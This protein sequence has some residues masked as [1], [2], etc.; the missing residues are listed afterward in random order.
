MAYSVNDT[1]YGFRITNIRDSESL[2]GALYE[3]E[4]IKTGAQLCWAEDWLEN[5]LFC[6]GFQTIPENSTGVFHILEHSV[7]C[8]SDQYPVREPFVELLKGSMNTFLNAMTYPDKT[9]YPVSS[10]NP[11]DFYNLTSVY[12]DAVF[13]PAILHNKNIFYQEGHH[14]ELSDEGPSNVGVVYNEMKGVMSSIDDCIEL[15]VESILFPDTCYSHNSGGDPKEILNL[16]YEEFIDTYKTYYHPSN[17]KIFL[18]GDINLDEILPLIDSY[19]SRYEKKEIPFCVKKQVPTVKQKTI[20]YDS[21]EDKEDSDYLVF[22]KIVSDYTTPEKLMALNILIGVLC[23]T[24]DSPLQK[25]LL[26]KGLAKD[27]DLLVTDGIIQPYSILLL[28]NTNTEKEEEIRATIKEVVETLLKEGINKED[29]IAGLNKNEYDFKQVPEPQGLYHAT[30][31]YTSWLYGGDPLL[32]LDSFS[33]FADLRKRIDTGFFESLLEEFLLDLSSW[34]TLYVHPSKTLGQELEE[35]EASALSQYI[36]SLTEQEK[37]LLKEE[38][39]ALQKWQQTPETPEQLATIPALSLKDVSPVPTLIPT[40][41]HEE[42]GTTILFHEQPTKGITNISLYFRL[43]NYSLEE[44]TKLS[45]LATLL[46]EMPTKEHSVLEF[47]RLIKTYL[48]SFHAELLLCGDETHIDNTSPYFVVRINVLNENLDK[49]F[50]ILNEFLLQVDIKQPEKIKEQLMQLDEYAKQAVINSGHSIAIACARSHLSASAAASEA[51]SGY[52]YLKFVRDFAAN[53]DKKLDD[54]IAFASSALKE[55]IGTDNLSVSITGEERC[56]IEPL[57]SALPKGKKQK[58]TASYKTALPKHMGIPIPAQISYAGQ[59]FQVPTNG[60]PVDGSLCVLSNITSLSYLWN[61][62]RVQGGAYGA[63]MIA[64][65][66]G[67]VACYSFRDP[68]PLRS[69]ETFSSVSEFIKE[70]VKTEEE[71]DKFI[72]SQINN[73]DPLRSPLAS[74]TAGDILYLTGQT[75]EVRIAFR[76]QML[77]TKKETLLQWAEQFDCLANDIATCVVASEEILKQ[78][79]S[80]SICNI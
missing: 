77:R 28:R 58:G 22:A 19:L 33:A 20:Y 39:E 31:A 78:D 34:S 32:Y 66:T 73:M 11:Q 44:L 9:I 45:F 63:G 41:V 50:E 54:Y 12:L 71:L 27:V 29:L 47:Q 23:G 7:L 76:E 80:R 49:A 62:I 55:F 25:A 16:T 18:D 70:F 57:L 46:E 68:S 8:G 21:P 75:E 24:N 67:L 14:V 10:R 56:S 1:L 48:G 74:G 79:S 4:H 42:N 43:G 72:I 15:G 60:H 53:V 38:N 64:S 61:R 65:R 2:G 36:G 59:A 17:A 35:Q 40:T 5:K 37:I 52:T 3:M 13:A 30:T 51:T 26:S 6:I 69:L